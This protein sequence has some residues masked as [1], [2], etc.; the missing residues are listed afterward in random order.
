MFFD[1]LMMCGSVRVNMNVNPSLCYF[2]RTG[3][4]MICDNISTLTHCKNTC[5]CINVEM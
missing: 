5:A 4:R 2:V 3:P 1:L